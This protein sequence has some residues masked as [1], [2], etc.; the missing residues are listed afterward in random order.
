V[1]TETLHRRGA[2]GGFNPITGH[3][4]SAP[5]LPGKPR[6]IGGFHSPFN[7]AYNAGGNGGGGGGGNGGGQGGQAS[8]GAPPSTASSSG[9]QLKN[10]IW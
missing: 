8:Y 7:N 3:E 9:S 6:D 4:L 1:R 10:N 5:A 2:G